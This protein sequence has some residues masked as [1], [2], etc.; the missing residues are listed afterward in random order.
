MTPVSSAS[1]QGLLVVKR[2]RNITSENVVQ[3]AAFP[4]APGPYARNFLD[5]MISKCYHKHQCGEKMLECGYW[6]YVV[7]KA[8]QDAGW[9]EEHLRWFLQHG[10]P[11]G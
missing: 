9:I 1:Q 5:K 6:A 11:E 4:T 3:Q 2:F 10:R 7:I 8:F